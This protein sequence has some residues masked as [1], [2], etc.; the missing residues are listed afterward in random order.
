M[1]QKPIE[2]SSRALVIFGV[3]IKTR[4]ISGSPRTL[5]SHVM[6]A[7][8]PVD[9]TF[10]KQYGDALPWGEISTTSQIAADTRFTTLSHQGLP[11]RDRYPD[12]DPVPFSCVGKYIISLLYRLR[13]SAES[14]GS[15]RTLQI[16]LSVHRV[17]ACIASH[18]ITI[19]FFAE[20]KCC[21]YHE[22]CAD[23]GGAAREFASSTREISIDSTHSLDETG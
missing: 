10:R 8:F 19:R 12:P 6:F 9:R 13:D 20:S 22:T 18:G 1:N 5:K 7:I 16:R 15:Y 14:I 4:Y 11:A 21:P 23:K 3:R 2:A 17:R